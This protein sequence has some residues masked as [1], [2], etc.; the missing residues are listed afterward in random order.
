MSN[1][2]IVPVHPPKVL[3]LIRLLNS[4]NKPNTHTHVMLV[5]TTASEAEKIWSCVQTSKC[6]EHLKV[7]MFV[8]DMWA[9]QVLGDHAREYLLNNENNCVVNFKKFAALH[10]AHAHTYQFAVLI[11]ADALCVGDLDSFMQSARINYTK[12]EWW[13]CAVD[14]AA[15]GMGAC[16]LS[17]AMLGV[18]GQNWCKENRTFRVYDWFLDP[19]S[20]K[21]SDVKLM[22]DHMAVIHG[23]LSE[24]FKK[25]SWFTFDFIVFSQWLAW[26]QK[27]T[28]RDYS[29]MFGENHV[30]EI[31][32]VEQLMQLQYAHGHQATW[33]S[34]AAWLKTPHVIHQVFPRCNMIYHVDRPWV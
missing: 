25:T 33:I 21:L 29:H 10:H 3:D 4:C 30:P 14:D 32:S 26:Q 17:T 5:C 11:D 22:F 20:Y 6:A 12:A 1:L 9:Q 16:T 27:A 2:L 31:L 34:T 7:Q 18:E 15:I 24:F 13:G 23:G 8:V 28:I 19:P